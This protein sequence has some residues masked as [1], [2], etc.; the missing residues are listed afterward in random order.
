MVPA[1]WVSTVGERRRLEVQKRIRYCYDGE[2]NITLVIMKVGEVVPFRDYFPPEW[3]RREHISL[4]EE[5][6]PEWVILPFRGE[7]GVVYSEW[8]PLEVEEE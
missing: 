2:G 5:D 6:P 7:G 3:S 8:F 1:K 4:P